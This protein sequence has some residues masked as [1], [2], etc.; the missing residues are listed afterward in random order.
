MSDWQLAGTYLEA[1]NCEAICPCRRIGGRAG[2]RST[3]GICMGA[4]SWKI[5]L[6]HADGV[7]LAD[8]GVVLASRYS[9]D[10]PGSP[11]TYLLYVDERGDE[12]QRQALAEIFC[13]RRGGTALK[14]FPWAF[15]PAN[16]LG[17]RAATI[18][19]DHAPGRGW[20]RAGGDV[21]VRIREPVTDQETV[22][23]VI[24]GHHRSGRELLADVL[25]VGAG[26]LEFELTGVC[27]Y[28]STFEYSSAD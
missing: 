9:D 20:F 14:Q 17:V 8:L 23:C 25:E 26:A 11:W 27:A 7:E 10:E 16:V 21:S 19:I 2:G 22:T 15:K 5:G 13:G 3:H 28:E 24:P 12:A 1:C 6:G 18:E 4:L